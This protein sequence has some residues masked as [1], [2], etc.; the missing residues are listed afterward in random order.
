MRK[1]RQSHCLRRDEGNFGPRSR[2][3]SDHNPQKEVGFRSGTGSGYGSYGGYESGYG[4]QWTLPKGYTRSDERIR[5][6]VC[7][8]LGL[9]G[10]DVSDVSVEVSKGHVTLEGTVKERHHKHA[11]EDCADDCM[12]VQGVENRI[13]VRKE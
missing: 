1:P 4:V 11:I 8:H 6:D 7:E 10:L 3:D 12:G 5:E 13:R 2:E 9:S